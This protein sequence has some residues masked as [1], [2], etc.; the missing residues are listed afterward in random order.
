M[1][2]LYWRVRNWLAG[3]GAVQ[4]RLCAGESRNGHPCAMPAEHGSHYC[5]RHH[6][7]D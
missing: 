1:R 7:A 4:F 2:G 5:W 6:G 3:R